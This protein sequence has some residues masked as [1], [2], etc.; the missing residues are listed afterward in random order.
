MQT[1][2]ETELEQ[3]IGS[4]G[5]TL[6]SLPRVGATLAVARRQVQ[7]LPHA[8][9]IT[10]DRHIRRRRI[11]TQNSTG[12]RCGASWRRLKPH[13]KW[14]AGDDDGQ[15]R[16]GS[17]TDSYFGFLRKGIMDDGI[18]S[19]DH[20]ALLR[21]FARLRPVT[22]LSQAFGVFWLIYFTAM[23]GERVQYDLRKKMFTH[24]QDLSF[25]YF[26]RTP[27]GWIM[28]RL[29]SDPTRIAELVTWGLLDV[30]A[31]VRS[32]SSRRSVFMLI[33]NWRLA[34]IVVTIVPVLLFVAA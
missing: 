5:A 21:V 18:A 2:I 3:E 28:S 33:I 16:R 23:L 17:F 13:W 11:H 15:R 12:T 34:L 19:G 24:L 6:A 14:V 32:P 8:E 9:G 10:R 29:T 1:R 22:V 26:D 7:D 30:D 27:V 31:G 4:V 20:A 25:S